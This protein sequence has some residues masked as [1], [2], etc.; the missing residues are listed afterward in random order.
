MELFIKIMPLMVVI[1]FLLFGLIKDSTMN[2]KDFIRSLMLNVSNFI[3]H[4]FLF[5]P[6][7]LRIG[8]IIDVVYLGGC[9]DTE[10]RREKGVIRERQETGNRYWCCN[11]KTYKKTYMYTIELTDST[12]IK[13][14]S[15]WIQF[16]EDNRCHELRH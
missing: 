11:S 10:I 8:K 13:G 12:R 1:L 14:H 6:H 7:K 9:M 15:S 5:N 3:V 16:N 4:L 2:I